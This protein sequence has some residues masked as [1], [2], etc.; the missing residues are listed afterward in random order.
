[1]GPVMINGGWILMTIYWNFTKIKLR[2]EQRKLSISY[3]GDYCMPSRLRL[4]VEIYIAI[5]SLVTSGNG[6]SSCTHLLNNTFKSFLWEFSGDIFARLPTLCLNF[7]IRPPS[8]LQ[9][10][11]FKCVFATLTDPPGKQNR[12]LENSTVWRPPLSKFS[13][14]G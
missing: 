6:L 5:Q 10:E 12:K 2:I 11:T 14:Y 3:S 4:C 8:N 7:L 13:F 1:M 9:L